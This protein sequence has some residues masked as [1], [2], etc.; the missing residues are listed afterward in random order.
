MNGIRNTDGSDCSGENMK[1]A[2]NP[3]DHTNELD[4]ELNANASNKGADWNEALNRLTTTIKT[5]HYSKKTL[6]A[7]WGWTKKFQGFV[8]NKSVESLSPVDVKQFVEHLAVNKKVAAST[9]NQAFNALLFFYKHIIKKDFGDQ[10]N[11]LRAKR[12]PYIPV[13]LSREEIDATI[14]R[15]PYPYDL[16]VKLL[17]GCG[18]RLFE[19]IN[20]RVN[21][22]NFDAGMLTV[23]DGKG[24][25]DRT[26]PL[27]ESLLEE[28]KEHL[29]RVK[30]LHRKDLARCYDGVFMFDSIEKKY[31]NCAKDLIWQWFFPAKQ[32]TTVPD[33]K[34]RRRYHVHESQVQKAIKAAVQQA[35][36]PKRATAHTFRHS[37]ATH[38]LQANYDIRTIQVL[39]GHSDVRT[40]MI[41]THT[42][43]STTKKELRSPLDFN[44]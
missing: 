13:V 38:L 41:Y 1:I 25:K 28:L 16:I 18:L 19:C 9:Q 39:M 29:R 23:H 10:R 3:Q 44:P 35:Q 2:L 43:K 4:N 32:L 31:K 7:Y 17:F 24:K 8:Y 21:N 27:P 14:T 12:K 37:F 5:R 26:L 15:L 6:R 22:F 42:V 11:N 40:T 36:I 34:E 20:L 33:T 30:N